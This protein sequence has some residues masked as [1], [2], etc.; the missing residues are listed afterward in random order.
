MGLIGRIRSVDASDGLHEVGEDSSPNRSDHRRDYLWLS[1]MLAQQ[2]LGIVPAGNLVTNQ[3][4]SPNSTPTSTHPRL[5]RLQR[6]M[7]SPLCLPQQ[8]VCRGGH[9]RLTIQTGVGIRPWPGR[10]TGIQRL[11]GLERGRVPS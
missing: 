11:G 8:V 10:R 1:V 9:D 3:G 7:A 5:N 6:A 4:L 2:G